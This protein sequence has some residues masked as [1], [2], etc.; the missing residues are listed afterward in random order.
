MVL[1]SDTYGYIVTVQEALTGTSV[2][3][4]NKRP[5][6]AAYSLIHEIMGTNP[7]KVAVFIDNSNIFLTMWHRRHIGEKFWNKAY[8]PKTLAEKLVG[9][10]TLVFTGF[11]CA[12]PPAYL[13]RGN[14]A[15]RNRY[16]LVMRYYGLVEKLDAVTVHYATVNGTRGN[17]QE[18]GLDSKMNVDVVKMAAINAFDTAIIVSNDAD[19]VPAVESAKEFGKKVEVVYFAGQGSMELRLKCDIPRKAKPTFFVEIPGYR[20]D[21]FKYIKRDFRSF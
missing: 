3:V 2:L 9:N 6:R 11:Y 4:S 21:D 7:Q 14:E 19:Y 17:L 12:P 18:K 5:E 20:T 15:D 13:Q 10:R 8:C 1:T 16:E